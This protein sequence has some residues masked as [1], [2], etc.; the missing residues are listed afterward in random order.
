MTTCTIS[1]DAGG[2]DVSQQHMVLAGLRNSYRVVDGDADVVMLSGTDATT[3][4]R[5]CALGARAVVIDHPGRI[6]SGDLRAIVDAAARSGCIVV[7]AMRYAPRAAPAVE[8]LGSSQVDLVETTMTSGDTLRSSLVEQLALLR[9]M[10]GPADSV[11]KL[12]VSM[13][14][15]VLEAR[16]VNR[17]RVRVLLNGVASAKDVEEVV[18]HTVGPECR[19]T[20]R[21]DA[22]PL[23][24]PAEIRRLDRGGAIS[25][26]PVYQHAYRL[27]LVQLHRLLT[28]GDAGLSYSLE[29]LRQDVQLASSVA[30]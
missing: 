27:T 20:V 17:P 24:R 16:M 2:P 4:A 7:P 21:V 26:W 12:H 18:V 22:G 13:S 25:P 10:L 1:I 6:A 8:L 30:E 3:C 19:V 5:V 28:S 15:Y 9:V 11:E 29:H 14:H 23:A